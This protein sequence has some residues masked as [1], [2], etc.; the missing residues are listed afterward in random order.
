MKLIF[1]FFVFISSLA[2][3]LTFAQT[4]VV[5]LKTVTGGL[6]HPID[7]ASMDANRH[8]IGQAN[9]KVRLVENG[10]LNPTPYLDISPL[11]QDTSYNGIF[12]LCVHPQFAVNGYLYVQYFRKTDKA[13]VV[14][15]YTRD[16]LN[17]NRANPASAQVVF[18][19][20]YPTFGH[21]SGRMAFGPDGYLY[22]TTGDS[23]PGDRG[24]IGDPNGYAQNPRSP[25]GKLFRI[26]VDKGNPYAIPPGNPFTTPNDSIPD[27]LYAVGLRNPWRWSFDRLTGDLWIADVGQ[28]GWEEVN[29]T[30]AGATAPQ[31][32]GWRCY[33]GNVPYVT[34]GCSA[35]TTYAMP[36][37]TY[38]G[39]NNNSN[40]LASVTGGFVYRGERYPE[41]QG[42]Y[43][44][45]D[46]NAG[47]I[48]TL[49]RNTATGTYQ[50]V[51]QA[52]SVANLVSFGEG[53]DGELYVLSF[54][55]GTL[56]Q[57]TTDAI[58]SRQTGDWH[59]ASTW[60]C[61]CIPS[62]S[63]RVVVAPG[64]KVTVGQPAPVR[65]VR[66]LGGLRFEGGGVLRY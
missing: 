59:T 62:A 22:I 44:Y 65:S 55:S 16:S 10:I 56:Y 43:I 8:L 31:N 20:P 3:T 21:R 54:N 7:L 15:R 38:A 24:S 36:L 42:W 58:V 34:T 57:I 30:P 52:A 64:H 5:R 51:Q 41:L 50:N 19:V 66:V 33:E 6:F 28:D 29:F 60:D 25:F 27:E 35:T 9:G 45:G 1:T 2:V 40:Q 23:A 48:W 14:A 26:D 11:V 12:G 4:P 49:R 37:H 63:S 32:Y 39:Y 47:T 53:A 18:V 46:W 17:P 13:A 61:A